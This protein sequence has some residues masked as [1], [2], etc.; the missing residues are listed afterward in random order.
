MVYT[1]EL[2]VV[3]RTRECVL[4]LLDC[5][6]L[7]PSARTGECDGIA[8]N[9]SETVDKHS[10]TRWC[11]L[12]NMVRHLTTILMLYKNTSYH[13]REI[14]MNDLL[15]NRFRCHPKPSIVCHQNAFIVL[16][17]QVV[18]LMIVSVVV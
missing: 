4:I 5:I 8:T 9:A 11:A 7:F 10:F 6:N 14:T 18:S 16:G 17:E 2:G 13:S 15:R 3:L 1:V 12:R